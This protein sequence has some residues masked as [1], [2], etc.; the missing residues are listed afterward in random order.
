MQIRLD[1]LADFI[2]V[3]PL[4][5]LADLLTRA[6]V[7]VEA[8]VDRAAALKGV[9]VAEVLEVAAHPNADRLRVCEVFDGSERARVVCGAANVAQGQKVAWAKV[10]AVLP[11]FAIEKRAIRGVDSAGM[12]AA[13]AELGLEDKSDG[14]WVLPADAVLG[15]PVV[16]EKTLPPALTLGITP[17]RPDLLSHIGVA[18]EVAAA[19]GKRLLAPP[20]RL[21]EK[22]PDCSSLCRVVI[23]EPAGCRRYAARVVRNLKVGPSP[24]WLKERLEAIGQRSINN[25]VDATNYVLFETGQP[26]HAFDLGRLGVE[27]KLP[28][29]KVRA[30]KAGEKLVTLDGVERTLDADDLIIADSQRPVALAGI[31]GGGDSEV[32]VDTTAVLLESAYFDPA[33]VRRGARRHGLH[34]EASHRFERGADPGM[35]LK[36]LDRCA[37]LLAEIAQG[38]VAKGVVEV[39]QKPEPPKEILL[40]SARVAQILGVKLPTETVVQ[41]LDS[42]EIRCVAR[43]DNGLRFQAPTFRP[44]LTREIDLIEEI[45]RRYGYDQVPERLPD[46]SQD[47]AY[48][49]LP[50]TRRDDIRQ[51]LLA[52]GVS[53]VVTWGFGSPAAYEPYCAAGAAPVKIRNPLGEELSALRTSL[54]P[55]LLGV[56]GHNQRH[57]AESVRLFEIGRTFAPRQGAADEDAR[58][59]DLPQ[60]TLKV[61]VVLWGGRH[62]G[63]W[64]ERGER[65]DFSDLA[66]VLENLVAGAEVG[67]PLVLQKATVPR[68]HPQAAAELKVAGKAIG[69][70]GQ[71]HP[72]VVA[73]AGLTGP[74]LS[75]ELDLDVLEAVV[76]EAIR[77]RSLPRFPGTRRDV[78]VVAPRTIPAE[79]LRA[80][81]AANAGGAL[82]PKVV[83]NVR[84]FDVYRGKPIPATHTSL[85]FAIYYRLA[86]R[87]LTDVEVN[88]AFDQ[89]VLGLQA[90]FP[91]EVRR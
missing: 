21:T 83:E 42:L 61:G 84:V 14:I 43:N 6:G 26:L 23:E 20:W 60:E 2:E 76:A 11:A 56:L 78:A 22:G 8:V 86:E 3:P 62:Q 90:A 59:R 25:L 80:Y 32:S 54:T 45:A 65:L 38:E 82:G 19:T 33:R 10:G 51:A 71:L 85:A 58:D 64:Y 13:K 40:R 34:T 88:T 36:A 27:N 44:D 31:M 30:P 68:M 77:Y 39:A 17:N 29:I 72:D 70:A 28:T 35:T 12:L 67:L 87:T 16:T 53:E 79:E 49:P 52:A 37:Q 74:V 91:V 24:A 66:G 1:W 55:G 75:A 81:L 4:A 5:A 50:S 57:G 48:V 89:A 69:S 9:V 15:A 46:A 47:Y 73:A 41:L 7:E 63:R 18:R